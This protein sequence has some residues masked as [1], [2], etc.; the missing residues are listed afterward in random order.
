MQYF[1]KTE[2]CE[3]N[4]FYKASTESQ[5]PDSVKSQFP[6]LCELVEQGMALWWVDPECGSEYNIRFD[7]GDPRFEGYLTLEELSKLA[8]ELQ[9]LT[10]KF[11]QFTSMM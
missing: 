7:W 3:L 4:P 1:S 2:A 11:K 8:I 10:A 6:M 9:V 5:F